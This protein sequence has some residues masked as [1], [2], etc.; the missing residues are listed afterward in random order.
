LLRALRATYSN[1]NAVDPIG[2]CQRADLCVLDEAGVSGGGRDEYPALH[3]ILDHRF[4]EFKPTIIT[5]NNT[6]EQLRES[7][8]PRLVDRFRQAAF[9]VLVFAGASHRSELREHYLDTE[10]PCELTRKVTLGDFL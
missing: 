9:R 8:G 6:L 4:S 3:E 5:S 1:P 2:V 10:T 7:L